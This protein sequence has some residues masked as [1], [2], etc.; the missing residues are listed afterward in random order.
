MRKK[1]HVRRNDQVQ[2]VAGDSK[3]TRGRVLIAMPSRNKVLV[4]GVNLAWK[5]VKPSQVHPRGGRVE[6]EA[7]VDASNV[8]LLCQNSACE[9]HNKPVRTRTAIG[10][11]G[12]KSR[13]CVKCGNPIATQE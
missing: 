1:S 2:V 7:P 5:H 9:R 13:V 4:E 11:D 3:G 12:T 8:M 6:R 10:D